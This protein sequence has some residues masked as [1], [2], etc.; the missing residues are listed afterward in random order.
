MAADSVT[1]AAVLNGGEEHGNPRPG[2]IVHRIGDR[3]LA[4]QFV[5]AAELWPRLLDAHGAAGARGAIRA[6]T[7]TEKRRENWRALREIVASGSTFP[8]VDAAHRRCSRRRAF[9]ARPC[10]EPAEVIAAPT[11]P[12]A[13]SSRPSPIRR[14][15]TCA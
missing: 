15:A 2:M 5:G 3:Y 13:G 9:P 8:S 11:W 14:A 7:R 12:S 6:S 4:M 1:Y 10:C